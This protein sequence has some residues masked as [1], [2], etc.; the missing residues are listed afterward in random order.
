MNV[1]RRDTVFFVTTPCFEFWLLL[2][3]VDVRNEYAHNLQE[4]RDNANKSNKHTFTS[5]EVSRLAHHS[6]G[7]T[8]DI[9]KR[10]YLL[11]V[12]Y[13]I[14]QA[15]ECF[16]TDIDELIGNDVSHDTKKGKLGSNLPALFELLREVG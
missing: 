16:S 15:K 10:N 3:L 4:F 8:E 5:Y 14:R 2:H 12:N 1:K 6:K 11:K 9:F 7:I 13:A